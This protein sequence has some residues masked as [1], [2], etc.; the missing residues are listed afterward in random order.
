MYR[1]I[2]ADFV[3][4]TG[5]D[6]VALVQEARQDGGYAVAGIVQTYVRTLA[7]SQQ[8]IVYAALRSF[9]AHSRAELPRH[10]PFVMELNRGDCHDQ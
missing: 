6:V 2:L 3:R 8:P 9:F 1:S 10:N 7:G 5:H 4:Y